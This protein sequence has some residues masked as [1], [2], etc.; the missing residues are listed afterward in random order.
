MS[1]SCTDHF[2]ITYP[3]ESDMCRHY[4]INL[5][6]YRKRIENGHTIEEAL[7]KKRIKHK[8]YERTTNKEQVTDHLGN[9]YINQAAMCKHYGITNSNFCKRRNRGWTLKECLIGKPN[10][11]ACV[12][13]LGNEYKN[14]QEMCRAYNVERTTFEYRKGKGYSLAE[15][16]MMK[17]YTQ[18]RYI[19]TDHKGNTF[20]NQKEMCKAYNIKETTF[21]ERK[22]KG[23]TMKECLELS[24]KEMI[25]KTRHRKTITD[26][27]GNKFIGVNEMCKHYNININ[28]YHF[29]LQSGWS[30][31]ETLTIPRNTIRHKKGWKNNDNNKY[32]NN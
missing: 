30:L 27:N 15:C 4:G 12:D 25:I 24:T 5:T 21:K 18:K 19:I 13:H 26:H 10:T 31:K 11:S 2:G 28:T 1:K 16:L 9:I 20:L 8:P 32:K 23:F 7:S 14:E 17:P 29:R 6:T 3:S 22:A